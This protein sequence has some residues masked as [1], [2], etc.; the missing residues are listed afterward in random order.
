LASLIIRHLGYD[1]QFSLPIQSVLLAAG[2]AIA[3]GLI[4]GMYPARKAG[5]VSPM[6]ALRY[7]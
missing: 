1:W 7:E 3:I 5:R 6:E 2:I 4:F